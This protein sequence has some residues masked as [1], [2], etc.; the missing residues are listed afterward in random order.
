MLRP[1]PKER[2]PS[3]ARQEP[4][5]MMRQFVSRVNCSWTPR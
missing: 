5:Q 2:M 3:K 1:R 4:P